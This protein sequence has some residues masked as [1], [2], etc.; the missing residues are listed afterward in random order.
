MMNGRPESAPDFGMFW[1]VSPNTVS[2]GVGQLEDRSDIGTLTYGTYEDAPYC[3][4]R[5]KGAVFSRTG[6]LGQV[7]SFMPLRSL[8]L[9]SASSSD[10]TGHDAAI[11]DVFKIG[12]ASQKRGKVNINTTN[13]RVLEALF[14]GASTQSAADVADA[15]LDA[16]ANGRVF[17][18]IGDVFAVVPGL[19]GSDPHNDAAEEAAIAKVA[20]LITVRQNYFTII[21]CAQAVRDVSGKAYR[22]YS[23]ESGTPTVVTRNARYFFDTDDSGTPNG[24]DVVRDAEGKVVSFVDRILAEQKVLAVVYR[25][26]FSN[27][28]RVERLEFLTD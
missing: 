10:T 4:V 3:D 26:G 11:L 2:L 20:E 22:T 24:M 25:D 19:S 14:A 16:R 5:V 13:R 9:W 15:I 23:S 6:E 1:D 12:S 17:T 28:T 27:E 7:H 8:R 18:N 21:A